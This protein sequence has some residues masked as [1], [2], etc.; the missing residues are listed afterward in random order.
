[1]HLAARAEQKNATTIWQ[2]RQIAVRT[3]NAPKKVIMVKIAAKTEN[4][5]KKDMKEKAAAKK[6]NNNFQQ[7]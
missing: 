2:I 4:A 7:D 6:Q 1:M 5:P 3:A